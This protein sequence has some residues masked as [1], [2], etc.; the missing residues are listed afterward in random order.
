MGTGIQLPPLPTPPA[1]VKSAPYVAVVSPWLLAVIS[2]MAPISVGNHTTMLVVPIVLSR[3][4]MDVV[5]ERHEAI[6]VWQMIECSVVG[7]AL[8]ASVAAL[9][10]VAGVVLAILAVIPYG[11]V[12]WMIYLGSFLFNWFVLRMTAAGS[13]YEVVFEREAYTHASDPEYLRGRRWFAWLG[14]RDAG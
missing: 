2:A 12:F 14:G 7:L 4:R 9:D 1:N 5:T 3:D 8:A 13:Y 10:P 11:Y 6:H